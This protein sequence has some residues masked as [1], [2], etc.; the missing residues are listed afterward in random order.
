M[1]RL[2]DK[3]INRNRTIELTKAPNNPFSQKELTY[4]EYS[5]ITKRGFIVRKIAQYLDFN[6]EVSNYL[7]NLSLNKPMLQINE[8]SD[9]LEQIIHLSEQL[10]T[11]N[12]SR[13]DIP[14][15]IKELNVN[16]DM[17]N[18]LLKVYH[19]HKD[20]L[21]LHSENEFKSPTS[22]AQ[23]SE[24]QIYRE[25]IYA[26]TQGKF[27]LIDKEEIS[28]YKT[29]DIL[30]TKVIKERADIPASRA[31]TKEALDMR[32]YTG[33]KTMGLLLVL[34]EAITNVIKHAEHGKMTLM[35]C[36]NSNE[37]RIM[38]EDIGPGFPLKE[39]PKNTLL[40]GYSTKKS[41]GQGFTLMMKMAKSVALYTSPTGSTLIIIFDNCNVKAGDEPK[42][43][44][45]G[46]SMK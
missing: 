1:K 9:G 27:L 33:P 10:L 19:V 41:L 39:L 5:F 32:G 14:A 46:V 28:N 42:A 30:C 2:I 25:V 40:A 36:M 43:Y 13:E 4:N 15:E 45:E 11:W 18:A 24:W 23:A 20:D 26:A 21:F 6:G 37:L 31:I 29:D 17:K 22:D 35:E 12:E 44:S 8:S 3:V 34:S 16:N 7:Y 38:V